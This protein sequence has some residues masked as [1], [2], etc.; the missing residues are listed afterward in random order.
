M[1]IVK[2]VVSTRYIGMSSDGTRSHFEMWVEFTDGTA[3][4]QY[5]TYIT[6]GDGMIW[7]GDIVDIRPFVQVPADGEIYFTPQK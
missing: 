4:Y 5:Q 2:R 1:K 3:G 6:K 7:S